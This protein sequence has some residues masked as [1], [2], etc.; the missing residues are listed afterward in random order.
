MSQNGKG[1]RPGG[2]SSVPVSTRVPERTC[3]GCHQTRP[4]G[5][6]VRLVCGPTG[7]LFLDHQGKLPGRGAYICPQRSCAE[8]A[9]TGTRLRE[10]FR[11]EVTPYPVD[12]LVCAM[13]SV[14]EGRALACL[15]IARKAGRVVSGYTQ[16]SRAL[17]S[18][19]V[20][21]LLVAGDTACERLREYQRRCAN[22][23][24]PW[25]VFL[26]KARL[27][28]LTGRDECSAIGILETRL[29]TSLMFYLEAMGR[30]MER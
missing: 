6:F 25:R 7:Q 24:I 15:R 11:H 12:E 21:Y 3:V 29:S 9:S 14:M 17:M 8:Q 2:T 19:P 23:Q 5:Q 4:K 16:V 18:G 20:A 1:K 28:E 27:G 10:A 22:R 26:T 30:L 13:V